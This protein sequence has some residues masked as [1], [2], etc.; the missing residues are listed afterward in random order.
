[1]MAHAPLTRRWLRWLSK[2]RLYRALALPAVNQI[3]FMELMQATRNY[4]RLTWLGHPLRQAPLDL[5]TIQET[6]WRVQPA[7]LIE[8]GT[9]RGG[10]ALF[11]ANLFDLMGKGRVI[12]VDVARLHE[13]VHPRV[14]FLIASS[15]D[16]EVVA[17]MQR[18]AQAAGGPVMVILDDDHS[19]PHVRQELEAYS[20]LVTPRSY[21]LVQDG[22]VDTSPYFQQLR[23]GPL[24]AIRD[25][26]RCHPEFT[27]DHELC[28]RFVIT[29]HP[30]GW[31][32]RLNT[33]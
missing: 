24:P 17:H 3:F 23:P 26:L 20:P 28:D 12:S 21:L 22:S 4:D 14:E 5:W 13:Q 30:E 6:L 32:K 11:Y 2:T 29:H 15:V 31:L 19:A 10:S 27:V 1:M 7:L 8:C 9:D 25:F 16:P 18:A 33:P